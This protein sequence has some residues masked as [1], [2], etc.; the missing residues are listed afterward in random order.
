MESIIFFGFLLT[1]SYLWL[2]RKYFRS[3]KLKL[4]LAFCS[5]IRTF[6]FAESTFVRKSSNFLWLFAHLFVPLQAESKK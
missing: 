5:L 4:P 6:G 2:R 1:Y 3:K